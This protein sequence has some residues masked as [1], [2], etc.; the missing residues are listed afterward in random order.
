VTAPAGSDA[1]DPDVVDLLSRA[2]AALGV[3]G[4]DPETADTARRVAALYPLLFRGL[5]PAAVPRVSLSP[6]AG[7]GLVLVKDLPFYS[8]CAH[9]LLPFFGR[10]AVAYLPR[11]RVAGLGAIA[12][13]VD[14]FAARPQLQERL[15][16][17]IADCLDEQLRPGG[18]IVHLQARHMCMEMRGAQKRA[19]VEAVAARG[20]LVHGRERDECLR[21]LPGG[22]MP[23]AP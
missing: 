21:R 20:A 10:A 5:D 6:H 12:E 3:S 22:A 18:L 1:A 19:L 7:E 16:E 14:Y 15:V 9:H 23:A 13:V 2:Y 17:Q 8:M 4:D 11:G